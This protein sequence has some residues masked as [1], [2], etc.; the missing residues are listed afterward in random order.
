MDLI[1]PNVGLVFWTGLVFVIL[2]VLLTKFAWKPILG[3]INKREQDIAE[4]LELAKKTRAEMAALQSQNEAL[5]KEA[6]AERDAIV[7]DAR[8][9]ATKMVEEAKSKAKAEAD[10]MIEDARTAIQ[11]EKNAAMADV[12]S[13]IADLAVEIAEKI[14]RTAISDDSKQQELAAK[15][16]GELNLN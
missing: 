15:L 2:L 6:K 10:K 9:V 12:K 11:T 14:V 16:A 4:A 5:L 1:T 13:Q 8:E 7:K 3:M